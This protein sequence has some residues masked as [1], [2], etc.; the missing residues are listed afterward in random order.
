MSATLAKAQAI[1]N[2]MQR[3]P[4][5]LISTVFRE[6]TPTIGQSPMR[7]HSTTVGR[8]NTICQ[9]ESSQNQVQGEA[10]VCRGCLW[11]ER[12]TKESTK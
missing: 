1:L 7:K 10:A 2:V 5:S 12:K 3:P 8:K 4:R 6:I 9:K 11:G